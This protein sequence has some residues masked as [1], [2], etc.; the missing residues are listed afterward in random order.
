MAIF[1]N[2]PLITLSERN[3]P[4]NSAISHW[5]KLQLG[6]CKLFRQCQP[7]NCSIR[8]QKRF[9]QYFTQSNLTIFLFWIDV[10]FFPGQAQSVNVWVFF[11]SRLDLIFNLGAVHPPLDKFHHPRFWK[12]RKSHLI[13]ISILW[14][15]PTPQSNVCTLS[16]FSEKWGYSQAIKWRK[17]IRLTHSVE[18]GENVTTFNLCLLIYPP[19][20]FSNLWRGQVHRKLGSAVVLMQSLASG[21][22]RPVWI[23]VNTN[24]GQN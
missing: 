4:F 1:N 14:Y 19:I 13:Q 6:G 18:D 12:R 24:T 22:W 5:K 3:F 23:A 20:L 2:G 15:W 21:L 16:F 10:T 11:L 17:A 7:F 9:V 8:K